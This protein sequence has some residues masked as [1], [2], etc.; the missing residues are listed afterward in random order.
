MEQTY[1]KP[2]PRYICGKCGLDRDLAF[3]F[4]RVCGSAKVVRLGSLVK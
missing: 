1:K 4:C 3:D 2:S